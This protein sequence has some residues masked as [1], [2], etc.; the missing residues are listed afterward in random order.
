[1]SHAVVLVSADHL[2]HEFGRIGGDW[3]LETH[4]LVLAQ[5]E[6]LV[7]SFCESGVKLELFLVI[8]YNFHEVL[9][10]EF[11]EVDLEHGTF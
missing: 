8:Y 6:V 3:I 5:V 9:A 1:M 7:A 10:C 4:L 2:T 11:L